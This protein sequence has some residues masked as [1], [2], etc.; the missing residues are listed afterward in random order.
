MKKSPKVYGNIVSLL[1]FEHA[2][3]APCELD[4]HSLVNL[5]LIPYDEATD[6]EI[7]LLDENKL[8]VQQYVEEVISLLKPFLGEQCDKD[9]LL[10][11]SVLFRQRFLE[12]WLERPAGKIEQCDA[13]QKLLSL[14]DG[15]RGYLSKLLYD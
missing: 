1:D 10:G 8:D 15:H 3:I 6:K 4:I 7:I 11:Y 12:F 14:C 9:L 5:S 13:Y 2:V